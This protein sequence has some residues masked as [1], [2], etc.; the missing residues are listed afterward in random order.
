MCFIING[1]KNHRFADAV[2]NRKYSEGL[3]QCEQAKP[4]E[5]V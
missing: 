3:Y 4:A 2:R 5:V 1:C